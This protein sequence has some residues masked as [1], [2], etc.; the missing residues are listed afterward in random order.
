M[1]Y[2]EEAR[3]IWSSYV[4][5]RGPADTVQGELLR[6]VEYLREEAVR[7]GNVNW[8]SSH[9]STADFLLVVLGSSSDLEEGDLR[10]IGTEI[11]WAADG[12]HPAG[13]VLY[14][15]LVDRVV[16]WC[17]MHP[18]PVPNALDPRSQQ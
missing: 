7:N 3:S 8:N 18:V 11:R 2:L 13:D 16:E 15:Q 14:D 5:Q 12:A 17:L 4:P 10:E 1:R 9:A 6:A